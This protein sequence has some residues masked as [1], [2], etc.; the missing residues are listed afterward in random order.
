[1]NT[2]L[3][4]LAELDVP[5]PTVTEQTRP[6]WTAAADGKLLI[7]R[8]RSCGHAVFYPRSHCSA[9]WSEDL[10]W[11]EARG[12]GRLKSY[13]VVHKPGHPGWRKAAP[14]IIVLVALDEG[15]TMLSH[16]IGSTD[17]LAVG[18]RLQLRPT[19]VGDRVLP[20]F[21]RVP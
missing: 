10:S 3:E 19:A 9:C 2:P 11:V 1:M 8:C 12:T 20:F 14:Y 15:P 16:L 7:Q 17:G 5:G 6:F 21:E 4:T 13:S 18:D